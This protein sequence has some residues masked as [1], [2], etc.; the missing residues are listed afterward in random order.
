MTFENDASKL[1]ITGAW[2]GEGS[3][4]GWGSLL[5]GTGEDVEDGYEICCIR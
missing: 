4:W 3:I 2:C 1:K 5:E